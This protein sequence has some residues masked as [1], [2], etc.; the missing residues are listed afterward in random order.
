MDWTGP[1][2]QFKFQK[3]LPLTPTAYPSYHQLSASLTWGEVTDEGVRHG[4]MQL[5]QLPVHEHR[6]QIHNISNYAN[7]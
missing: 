6:K 3:R 7:R 2:K 5:T 1:S 4:A